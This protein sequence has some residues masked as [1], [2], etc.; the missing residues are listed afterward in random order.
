MG[1]SQSSCC[2]AIFITTPTIFYELT[3][4]TYN[5][6]KK[7]VGPTCPKHAFLTNN[8]YFIHLGLMGNSQ[9]SCCQGIFTTTPTIFYEITSNTY[10]I[11]KKQVGPTCPKHAFLTNIYILNQNRNKNGLDGELPK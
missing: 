8:F 7:Q 6:R 9:S 10:N 5:T 11:R 1:N 3:S 2:Q 4:D